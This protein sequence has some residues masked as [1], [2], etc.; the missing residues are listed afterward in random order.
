MISKNLIVNGK[1]KSGKTSG[2]IMPIVDELIEN[3]RSLLIIDKNYEYYANYADK[4]KE[5]GYEVKALNFDDSM[6]S[7]S[8][9]VLGVPY[10]F[11]KKGD[12]DKA[13]ELISEIV[14]A[15]F[16]REIDKD[17]FWTDSATSLV[18]G[19]ILKLFEVADEDEINFLSVSRFLDTLDEENIKEVSTFLLQSGNEAAYRDL[20]SILSA[21]YETRASILSV[22]RLQINKLV[23][24]EN[25]LNVISNSGFKLSDFLVT[26]EKTIINKK[27]ALFLIPKMEEENNLLI[28]MIISEAYQV[29]KDQ[30][31]YFILDN[32]DMIGKMNNFKGMF[33]SS[34][35]LNIYMIVGTR[36][37]DTLVSEYGKEILQ[38]CDVK[39]SSD[40]DGS[41][42]DKINADIKM[43]GSDISVK[44]PDLEKKEIKTFDILDAMSKK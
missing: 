22:A 41:D 4:L 37:M 19:Y 44:L 42:M 43:V 38:V 2:I 5:E 30:S 35:Y 27:C 16:P 29:C 17:P 40:L 23:N 10:D 6:H 1:F 36:D 34:S 11:Y 9:N 18:R 26:T 33:L 21:P 20:N 25:K 7:D 12:K 24:Y 14:G 8:V 3:G 31:W 15:I 13:Y 39:D 28:S 32:F